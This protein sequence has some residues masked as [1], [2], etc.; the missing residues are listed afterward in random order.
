MLQYQYQVWELMPDTVNT[1]LYGLNILFKDLSLLLESVSN[2]IM[3]YCIFSLLHK[4]K[5][6]FHCHCYNSNDDISAKM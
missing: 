2:R 1:E 4:K 6:C 3:F 5:I